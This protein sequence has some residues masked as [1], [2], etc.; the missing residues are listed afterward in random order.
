MKIGII[1]GTRGLGR[2]IAWYMKD[3]DFDVTITGRD[4]IVGKQVSEELGIKYSDNNKKIVQDSDIVIISV[5]IS[6]TEAVIEELSNSKDGPLLNLMNNYPILSTKA[7]KS[8]FDIRWLNILAGLV[9]PIGVFFYFRIW[10]FG[11]RLDKDLKTIIKTNSDIQE[12]IKNKS[13]YK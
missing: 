5:P 13:L 2:T 6:S 10:M 12:R 3:F 8:P 7:H 1:G 11:K 4:S 9:I